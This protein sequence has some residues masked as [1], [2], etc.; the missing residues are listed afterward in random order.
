MK[1][2][3]CCETAFTFIILNIP[4]LSKR[5]Q[6][7]ILYFST[8]I[9][10]AREDL[11]KHPYDVVRSSR[12]PKVAHTRVIFTTPQS[13]ASLL[14]HTWGKTDLW[15]HKVLIFRTLPA[16]TYSENCSKKNKTEDEIS[17]ILGSSMTSVKSTGNLIFAW[18]LS[19]SSYMM[20][21]YMFFLR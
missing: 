9:P 20:N 21:V 8:M 13:S 12:C 6:A 17:P 16:C 14:T 19:K 7:V 4:G 18:V 2:Q 3:H 10:S 15:H 11:E 1:H 5:L